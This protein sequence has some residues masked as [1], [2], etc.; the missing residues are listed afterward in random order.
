MWC[1]DLQYGHSRVNGQGP[2]RPVSV[3]WAPVV[4]T[5]EYHSDL[6]LCRGGAAA[7]R[8][9]HSLC[10]HRAIFAEFYRTGVLEICEMLP[11]TN[12]TGN[13]LF[14][15]QGCQIHPSKIRISNKQHTFLI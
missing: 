8:V 5:V 10:D 7:G 2:L 11:Y 9:T 1:V 3:Q 13:N 12:I 4:E 15:R 14:L 6:K